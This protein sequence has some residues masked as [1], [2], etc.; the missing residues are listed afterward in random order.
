MVQVPQILITS[1]LLDIET[2]D[3]TVPLITLTRELLEE[4]AREAPRED[5]RV[6]EAAGRP[7]VELFIS[8]RLARLGLGEGSLAQGTGCR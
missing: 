5:R 6:Q 1:P 7:E 3:T 8:S 2:G 4:E